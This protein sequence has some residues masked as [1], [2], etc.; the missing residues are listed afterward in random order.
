MS[1]MAKK[2]LKS[3]LFGDRLAASAIWAS[4]IVKCS[5]RGMACCGACP[6]SGVKRTSLREAEMSA[7]D[8]KRII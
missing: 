3:G 4:E 5:N 6:L 8:P 7:N 1:A 2:I